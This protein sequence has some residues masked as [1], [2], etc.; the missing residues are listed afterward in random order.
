MDL[1]TFLAFYSTYQDG[2]QHVGAVGSTIN[3][4]NLIAAVFIATG[5][6]VAALPECANG[7]LIVRPAT[8]EEIESRGEGTDISESIRG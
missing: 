6:D 7:L 5:Q 4:G 1:A 3:M 2:K 8:R